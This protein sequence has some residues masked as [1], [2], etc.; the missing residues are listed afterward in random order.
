[1]VVGEWLARSDTTTEEQMTPARH[2]VLQECAD[3]MCMFMAP[4]RVFLV[5]DD[6]SGRKLLAQAL[7]EE[8]IAVVGQAGGG[9]DGVEQ[10]RDLRPEVVVM[11][12][13]LPDGSGIEATRRIKEEVPYIQVLLLTAYDGE[14]PSRSAQAVG[15][16]AYLLKGCPLSL[17]RDMITSAATWS[18]A[19]RQ[20]NAR[21]GRSAEG[22]AIRG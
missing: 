7:A 22:R 9:E 12:L 15:A 16:F 14:L 19:R 10:V 6:A 2:G 1:L 4:P 17:I 11:D 18:R 21:V 3:P 13:R 8:G 5:D 20:T